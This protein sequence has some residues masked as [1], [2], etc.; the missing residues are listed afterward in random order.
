M[1]RTGCRAMVHIGR[2]AVIPI[3]RRPMMIISAIA[4]AEPKAKP[5][6]RPGRRR[7]HDNL[8]RRRIHNWRSY[9]NHL[10][11]GIDHRR[12]WGCINWSRRHVNRSR[13]GYVNRG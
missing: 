12:R 6:H 5:N 11:S 7:H 1:I 8:R 3:R 4:E 10:R 2:R 13:R 9:L